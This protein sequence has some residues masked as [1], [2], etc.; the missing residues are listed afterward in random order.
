MDTNHDY[1]TYFQMIVN[2]LGAIN[3]KYRKENGSWEW[4]WNGGFNLVTKVEDTFWTI[5]IEIPA[6]Q[7]HQS[8]IQSGDI[9][10]FNIARVRIANASEYGQ[11]TPTYGDA[12]RPDRF[13]FL[14]F[15]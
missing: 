1:R 5:E 13:G 14:I 2:S 6:D 11:W 10:G 12:H 9:W 8:K 7:L 15:D 3:D 4:D